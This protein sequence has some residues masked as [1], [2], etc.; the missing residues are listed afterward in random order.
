MTE[1][2]PPRETSLTDRAKELLKQVLETL[3]GL[4]PVLEP[5]LMPVRARDPRRRR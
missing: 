5:E 2:D 1:K 3:E 4:I